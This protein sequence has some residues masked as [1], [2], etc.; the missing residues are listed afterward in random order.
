MNGR[1]ESNSAPRT[2]AAVRLRIEHAGER[3]WR[4]ED[5]RD[6]PFTGVAKALSRLAK[7]GAIERLSKGTYYRARATPFGVS[8]PNPA[9]I[10]RI[11]AT[12]AVMFPS[13]ISAAN[14]LGFTTQ[15]ASRIELA[16]S[17]S[18]LPRKLI[19]DDV[20]IHTRR[21]QLWGTLSQEDGAILDFL[22][23]GGRMSEM[24]QEETVGRTLELFTEADRYERLAAV[25]STEPPRVRAMM[26]ALGEQLGEKSELLT[27]LRATLNPLSRFDFGMLSGLTHA[28]KWFAKEPRK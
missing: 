2:A 17:A 12:R 3:L 15:A 11:A 9:A 25:A 21:P 23:R 26:G 6:L 27:A 24:S 13:G 8:R 19:G 28:R 18:S 10:Q 5:F 14:L 20:V 7:A 22:R 16:T 4:H 1:T